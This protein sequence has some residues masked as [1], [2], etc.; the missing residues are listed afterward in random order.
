M[1]YIKRYVELREGKI[2]E[3]VLVI[4]E[5]VSRE[6]AIRMAGIREDSCFCGIGN[7][8]AYLFYCLAVLW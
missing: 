3:G 4:A 1:G 2:D 6:E 5:I 8:D 7:I